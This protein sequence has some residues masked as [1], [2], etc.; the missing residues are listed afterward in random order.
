VSWSSEVLENLWGI[1]PIET[2][3]DLEVPAPSATMTEGVGGWLTSREETALYLLGLIAN[4]PVLEVGPWLGKSTVCIASGIAASGERKEF[5][6]CE[7]NP[8]EDSWILDDDGVRQF[9]TDG[10]GQSNSGTPDAEWIQNIQPIVGHPDGVIGLLQAN[11]VRAGVAQIVDVVEGNFLHTPLDGP[12]GMIFTDA[13][14]TPEEVHLNSARLR[15]L[16]APNAILACHDTNDENRRTLG[17]Y[18][19][20]ERETV[21]DGLFVGITM[22]NH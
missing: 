1:F 14:H 10:T 7:L 13:M 9:H 15:E 22:A 6:T 20:F 18:I 11:L 21:V 16:L 17:E 4:G 2:T 19:Q 8:T 3:F 5:T 12:Y